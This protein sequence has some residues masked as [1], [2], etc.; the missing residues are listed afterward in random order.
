VGDRY[1]IKAA[2][3]ETGGAFALIEAL[4]P[5]GG[6]PPPHIH[7]RE[8]EA[9][10]VLE[11]ELSLHVDGRDATASAGSWIMLPKGS[12]HWFKNTGTAPVRMLIHV[13]PAGLEDYF[14]EVGRIPADGENGPIVPS[15]ED[16]EKLLALAPKYGLEIHANGAY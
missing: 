1:T 3:S 5:P 9:F 14:L 15:K 12:L 8:D 4:V 10:Y 11:G 6:G 2:G 7:R 16:F 13:S